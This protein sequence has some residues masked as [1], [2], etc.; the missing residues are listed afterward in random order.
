VNLRIIAYGI[1]QKIS[2]IEI[3]KYLFIKWKIIK[4][5]Q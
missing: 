5:L 3:K 1:D 4:Y 2:A